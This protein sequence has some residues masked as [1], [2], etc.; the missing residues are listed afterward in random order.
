MTI[1]LR[2]QPVG[3]CTW[4]HAGSSNEKQLAEQTKFATEK[5]APFGF[6]V[7]QIDDGWQ[8][9]AGGGLPEMLREEPGVGGVVL[10]QE[11]A[12]RLVGHLTRS[13]AA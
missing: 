8:E 1:K 3:Y 5:L 12:D 13:A 11:G 6:S 2:P 10:D 7:M 4:Y 9:G